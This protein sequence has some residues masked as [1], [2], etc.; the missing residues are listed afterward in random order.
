MEAGGRVCV[1]TPIIDD[2]EDGPLINCLC[3]TYF[4]CLANGQGQ[5]Y[6]PAE[7]HSWMKDEG[8]VEIECRFLPLNEAVFFGN[9]P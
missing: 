6:S 4:L 1:F 8:F 3:G 7:I 5:F 2:T 9:K